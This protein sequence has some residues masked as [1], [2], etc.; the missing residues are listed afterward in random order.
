[1]NKSNGRVFIIC[2][3]LCF[4]NATA[5]A[6]D[7]SSKLNE[8]LFYVFN[9]NF[10]KAD[11]CNVTN[12]NKIEL[13]Y[14]SHYSLFIEYSLGAITYDDFINQSDFMLE[15][16]KNQSPN[17]D[18][19]ES[20]LHLQIGIVEY[21]NQN[22]L[23][24]I[25]HFNKGYNLWDNGNK[26]HY[27]YKKLSGI[28]NILL[29]QLP[30]PYKNWAGWFGFSGSLQ[31]GF[32][33]LNDCYNQTTSLNGYNLEAALY[34]S[35][36]HL[37]FTSNPNLVVSFIHQVKDHVSSDFLKSILIRCSIK[38][39]NP[40]LT[41]H[42][43]TRELDSNS[44]IQLYYLQGKFYTQTNNPLAPVRLNYFVENSSSITFKADALR[45]LS[46]Y[47]LINGDTIQYNACQNQI[48]SISNPQ[49]WEDKQAIYEN[50]LNQKPNLFLLKARLLFD[51]GEY[52]E[53]IYTLLQ[54]KTEIFKDT[55]NRLEYYYRLG[56]SYDCR[57]YANKA[58]ENYMLAIK[59]QSGEK[60]YFA[61]YAAIYACKIHINNHDSKLAKEILFELKNMDIKEEK[62]A[63][64]R[65]IKHL[66]NEI[67][68]TFDR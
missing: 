53:S 21:Q 52:N 65:E 3:A 63:I 68:I 59:N 29:S 38:H 61:P 66:E 12:S 39:R 43:L 37:K 34:L 5:W 24:A 9:L 46:W 6:Q 67:A 56:R 64:E 17:S 47:Y 1:M 42:W 27:N 10:E 49:T 33:A 44:F 26:N 62:S 11:S 2:I 30:E 50:S 15:E 36:C 8:S 20:E 19:Y 45:Y 31:N 54:H 40:Y 60:R 41:N 18:I 16:F 58:L 13:N 35:F 32:D 25:R 4:I 55:S 51:N 57:G 14:A 7:F 28:Y 48:T 22:Y 23:S